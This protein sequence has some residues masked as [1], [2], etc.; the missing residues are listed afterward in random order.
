MSGLRNHVL[1]FILSVLMLSFQNCQTG[2]KTGSISDLTSSLSSKLGGGGISGNG[3]GYEGKLTAS[4]IRE[5]PDT[6]CSEKFETLTK[7]SS[8]LKIDTVNPQSCQKT[9][10]LVSS[11]FVANSI[12]SIIKSVGDG[13]YVNTDFLEA[14]YPEYQA[15]AWC[16]TKSDQNTIYDIIILRKKNSSDFI[17]TMYLND[18]SKREVRSVSSF[19]IH[20][21]KF[22]RLQIYSN[23]GLKLEILTDKTINSELGA[24]RSSVHFSLDDQEYERGLDCRLGNTFDGSIWPSQPLLAGD[25]NNF[26]FSPYTGKFYYNKN[27]LNPSSDIQVFDPLQRKNETIKIVL[28]SSETISSMKVSPSKPIVSFRTIH[29]PNRYVLYDLQSQKNVYESSQNLQVLEFGF[30]LLGPWFQSRTIAE[31]L[32]DGSFTYQ[33]S[34]DLYFPQI[35]SYQDYQMKLP[36][37]DKLLEFVIQDVSLTKQKALFEVYFGEG[38]FYQSGKLRIKT[39]NIYNDLAIMDLNS[40]QVRFL[41]VGPRVGLGFHFERREVHHI[42]GDF[43]YATVQNLQVEKLIRISLADLNIEILAER[44]RDLNGGGFSGFYLGGN[45]VIYA[46]AHHILQGIDLIS[47]DRMVYGPQVQIQGVFMNPVMIGDKLLYFKPVGPGQFAT[48]IWNLTDK[49]SSRPMY[50][51]LPI[52]QFDESKVNFDP[53]QILKLGGNK[54][55]VTHKFLGPNGT[56]ILQLDTDFD[57]QSELYIVELSDVKSSFKQISN[58]Y[59]QYGAVTQIFVDLQKNIYFFMQKNSQQFLLQ[60]QGE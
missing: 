9:S 4:Y 30:S 24:Y 3:E 35:P 11:E 33:G 57:N 8:G 60:W 38:A 53:A 20:L 1:I 34:Y 15:Q 2:L 39:G 58:R 56:L 54:T 49:L 27:T 23:P 43:V 41:E 12:G 17:G 50:D 19:P 13:V 10:R 28:N 26:Q 36:D 21:E 31:V 32:N 16:Q 59:L 40:G 14:H 37:R 6:N 18:L 46:D 45:K 51:S 42:F 44:P 48:Q 47:G 25:L 5:I 29:T 22:D 55:F 7:D 52:L